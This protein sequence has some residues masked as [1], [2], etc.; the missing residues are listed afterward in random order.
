[1]AIKLNKP[2]KENRAY[3]DK[4]K[5]NYLIIYP[6]KV[7]KDISRT[8]NTL[9]F[10]DKNLKLGR[11]EKSIENKIDDAADS[12]NRINQKID[13]LINDYRDIVDNISYNLNY[14]HQALKLKQALACG[15]KY[16]YFST[17][18]NEK[19]L[20]E[21]ETMSKKYPDTRIIKNKE[22]T[23][24]DPGANLPPDVE[25][26][27]VSSREDYLLVYPNKVKED[28]RRSVNTLGFVDKDLP[29]DMLIKNLDEQK[30]QTDQRLRQIN[31]EIGEI[32]RDY[33]DV[34]ENISYSLDYS[35]KAQDLKTN[36]AHGDEYFYLSGWV[37]E[38][39]IKNFQGLEDKYQSSMIT[40]KEVESINDE[41]PTRLKNNPLVRPFEFMVN[42]YGAP[43]YNEIDPTPFFAI[44]Y[45]LLY[46]LMFGDLGQGLVFLALGFWLSTKNKTFGA[47]LKRIG[48]SA[49]VFGLMYG[50]FFGREDLIPTLLIKPFDNIMT[51]LIASVAFGVG[52][53]VI[54]YI[55]GIY[56]SLIHI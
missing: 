44:T 10:I 38:S 46:G 3:Q 6:K 22:S 50:S 29:K 35:K 42:M 43:S 51:V 32:N 23:N 9:G 13:D 34:L 17:E 49:S 36:M 4:D 27:R 18:A 26:K 19:Q 52:L 47:L 33:Q 25:N 39:E 20:K 56:L 40:T 16:F 11:D 24:Q 12:L 21:L 37:P 55:I 31:D 54:S 2:D 15:E 5:E 14:Q 53:M 1:M 48:I 7:E 28:V 41:P 8:I 30:E 45:M